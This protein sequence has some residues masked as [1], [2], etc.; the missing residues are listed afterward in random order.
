MITKTISNVRERQSHLQACYR[1]NAEKAL[2]TDQARTS[3]GVDT[4]P[5]HGTVHAGKPDT[6]VP[7]HFGIHAAVGGYHDAPNPG[8]MLC[9]ALAACMDS[10]LRIIADRMGIVIVSLEVAVEAEI[11]V[12]GTLVVD[13]NVPVG[14]RQMRSRIDIQAAE[15]SDPGLL[16]KLV[17]AAEYS[18][19]NLQTL[20]S[21]VVVETSVNIG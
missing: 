19:V 16:Q 21:G 17:A 1:V 5:F 10:T 9:A 14:F 7:L 6:S 15:D 3:G 20:R 4:D 8:D 18:C 13:R 2:I 12:R 11:D